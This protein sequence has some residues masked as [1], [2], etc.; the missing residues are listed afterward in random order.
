MFQTNDE[1]DGPAQRVI[2]LYGMYA[3]THALGRVQKLEAMHCYAAADAWRA[4]LST[5]E[6]LQGTQIKRA[7]ASTFRNRPK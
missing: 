4:T 1:V 6:N 5:I 3:T 2:R 7:E